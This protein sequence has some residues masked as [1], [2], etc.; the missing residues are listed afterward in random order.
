MYQYLMFDNLQY[1]PPRIAEPIKLGCTHLFK[2]LEFVII[3][4]TKANYLGWI[5]ES[6]SKTYK[7]I[8]LKNTHTD[9]KKEKKSKAL[10]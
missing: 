1:G 8:N 4:M 9:K 2:V 3:K 5:V 7:K 10:Y 6:I